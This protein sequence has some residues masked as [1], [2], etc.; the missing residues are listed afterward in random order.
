MTNYTIQRLSVFD[1][2]P[3]NREN[4]QLY[5]FDSRNNHHITQVLQN[6]GHE[7]VANENTHI[8]YRTPGGPIQTVRPGDRLFVRRIVGEELQEDPIPQDEPA[9][10]DKRHELHRLVDEYIE[11]LNQSGYTSDPNRS[12]DVN[13]RLL[14][15]S[16]GR[17]ITWLTE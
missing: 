15:N 3:L 10:E 14:V 2:D 11:H 16:L 8:S 5:T 17:L 1:P 4:G 9:L 13:D 12:L 6:Y 7:I